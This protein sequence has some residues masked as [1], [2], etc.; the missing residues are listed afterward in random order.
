MPFKGTVVR[1]ISKE[2]LGEIHAVRAG[3][4][5]VALTKAIKEASDEDIKT[6]KDVLSDMVKAAKAGDYQAFMD[7]DIQFHE[8]IVNLANMTDLKKLWEMCNIRL[9][10]AYS[11][12]YSKKDLIELAKNH[13]AIYKK[14]ETRDLSEIFE[15]VSGYFSIITDSMNE[16]SDIF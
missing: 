1:T 9:W 10:T 3:L 16:Q 7:Q 4:E 13:E 15:T 6:I 14:I 5:A 12:K 2:E 8:T 11:T